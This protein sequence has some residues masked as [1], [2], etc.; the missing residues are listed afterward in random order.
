MQWLQLFFIDYHTRC[1]CK[2][3]LT[4][5]E[6][7][8]LWT[9]LV[10]SHQFNR[11]PLFVRVKNIFLYLLI[12]PNRLH[13]AKTSNQYYICCPKRDMTKVWLIIGFLLQFYGTTHNLIAQS[14]IW[15]PKTMIL[16][17]FGYNIV[18]FDDIWILQILRF[19][20]HLNYTRFNDELIIWWETSTC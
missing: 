3:D 1:K 4:L 13:E 18:L 16:I 17:C 6:F 15:M 7:L 20:I 11:Y 19:T 8:I 2:K 5:E 14:F 12:T 9:F 10:Q